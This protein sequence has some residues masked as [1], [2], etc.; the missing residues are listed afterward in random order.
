M[1]VRLG[2][3]FVASV[4]LLFVGLTVQA[5]DLG[6]GFHKIK[7]GI[8]TFAPDQTTTTCSF[9]VTEAGVVMI[10][11]CNSPL[12]SRRMAAAI[13]KVTDK[14]IMFLIDTETHSDHTGNHFIF[15]PSATVIN[16]DGAGAGMKKEY[17]P[18]R[19]ETLAAQS[20]EMREALK[21][22]KMIPPHIEYK[23]R[24]TINLGERTFE[25]IYLKN[26]HSFADTAIWMPKER[27]LFAS[28]AANVRTF[29]N[30]RPTVV[31]P[32]VIASYKLMKSLN[33]E[34]V[35]AGHGQPTTTVIFDEYEGFYNLL[36]KRVG[37]MAAQGK[38]L[39][40]IKKE[41][42][43]PEYTDWQ[44]QDRLAVNID[45]AYKSVKK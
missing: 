41:L 14:P 3:F 34:V 43:M 38:S 40:E 31:L 11:S 28:S 2:L 18:K 36:M 27:V 5:Q 29:I 15:S 45:A 24:M 37:E 8:Y 20:P 35:I 6:P 12:D 25:L 17:N 30:L 21:G 26:V 7:D 13:K 1:K 23:D 16:A 44:G 19:A 33:P 9:A 42:K 32:D 39:D 10:D 4:A 22:E